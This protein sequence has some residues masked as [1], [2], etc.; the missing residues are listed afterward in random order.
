[1][2][3]GT[4]DAH[5]G[6]RGDAM[7]CA[8]IMNAN[9]ELLLESV[10]IHRAAAIMAETG[11]GF[12]PVCDVDGRAIG[13]VTDR[14]LAVRALAKE[15][16]PTSTTVASVMTSPAITCT[17][18]ADIRDAAELMAKERKYRLVVTDEEGRPVGILSLV[19]VVE[20]AHDRLALHTARAVLWRDALGPRGGA[21]PN[22]P[23]LKDDPAAR[24]VPPPPEE[25]KIRETVFTGGHRSLK[26]LKEF[27]T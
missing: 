21:G 18:S 26:D 3:D 8:D 15:L 19:D 25:I 1:M 16:V 5:R 7:K 6:D 9:L 10:T 27:P 13:V 20:K 24:A 14:D 4:L 22:E 17:A 2:N 23:L 11:V 12:L